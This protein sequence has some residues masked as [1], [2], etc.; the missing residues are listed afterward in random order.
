MG[1][2]VKAAES[3][4]SSPD[5]KCLDLRVEQGL[6]TNLVMSF[7]GVKIQIENDH[8]YVC[9][10]NHNLRDKSRETWPKLACAINWTVMTRRSLYVV[11]N[12]LG[13]SSTR[14]KNLQECGNVLP[15]MNLTAAYFAR[16]R[17]AQS[18]H[19]SQR[20]SHDLRGWN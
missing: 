10:K 18:T 17:P 4:S 9:R 14:F 2:R 12:I 20:K 19:S 5:A 15:A 11:R 7:P 1:K 8:Q 6:P 16:S 3:G 13:A